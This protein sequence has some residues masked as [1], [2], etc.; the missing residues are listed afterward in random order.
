MPSE[1]H[2]LPLTSPIRVVV[3]DDEERIRRNLVKLLDQHEGIEVLGT[4]AS[5]PAAVELVDKVEPDLV[6]LDLGLPGLDGIQVTQQVKQRHPKVE[7]LILT[8][9]D[10]EDRVLAAILAGAAG[11]L[12]KGVSTDRI[13]EAI[14]DVSFGG[15]VI[16]PS[17]AR[18]LLTRFQADP[19]TGTSDA[20]DEGLPPLSPRETEVLQVIA[21]GMS[22]R[23]AAEIL[24]LSRSTVR[25]H[26][27][28]I[29]AKL[30]VTNRTE[31]VA[32]GIRKGIID[33]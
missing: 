20:T 28:H 32:E 27:E 16:Q 8:V 23:E 33:L 13:V 24:H 14:H 5:G 1:R 22:N 11:Y 6:L 4:A 17:L 18:R 9:F 21:K 3:V 10:E 30:D 15:S 26:L 25:T 12:L 7:I 31:A 2:E 29:Y 19:S